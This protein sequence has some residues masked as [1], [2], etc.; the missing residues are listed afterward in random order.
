[1]K[2]VYEV[3][4]PIKTESVLHEHWTLTKKRYDKQKKWVWAVFKR[5]RPSFNLPC[6]VRLK[7]IG[8]RKMNCDNLIA[9]FK[10]IRDAVADQIIP[11]LKPGR[12]DDGPEILWQYQQCLGDQYSVEISIFEIDKCSAQGSPD[13]S[14]IRCIP[15][16]IR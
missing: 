14:S 15:F 7:R 8:K 9:S 5:D 16:L 6:V 4:L 2:L 1:L 11:G 10:W 12:A 13:E 3:S